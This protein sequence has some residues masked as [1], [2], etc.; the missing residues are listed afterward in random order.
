MTILNDRYKIVAEIAHGGMATIYKAIDL[1]LDRTVA[2]KLLHSHLTKGE[3]GIGFVNRFINEAKAVAK[4]NDPSIVSIYDQCLDGKNVY[5]VMEYVDGKN[6][7]EL[8][9]ES[10]AIPYDKALLVI[11][12]ILNALVVAHNNGIIHRDIKPENIMVDRSG[13]IRLTDFGIAKWDSNTNVSL[14]GNVLGTVTYMSPELVSGKQ[15]MFATDLYSLGIV[16]YELITAE[17]PF[18]GENPA[19]IALQHVKGEFPQIQKVIIPQNVQDFLD[20]LTKLDPNERPKDAVEAKKELNN[21][22]NVISNSTQI[23]TDVIK[24]INHEKTP[25]HDKT[26]KQVQNQSKSEA[27]GVKP[28]MILPRED[29]SLTAKYK[30][31]LYKYT[32]FLDEENSDKTKKKSKVKVVILLF[33]FFIVGAVGAFIFMYFG[34]LSQIQMPQEIQGKTLKQVQAKLS[35]SNIEY[36]VSYEFNDKIKKDLVITT[37]PQPGKY[38]KKRDLIAQIIVSKGIKKIKFPNLINKNW[39]AAEKTLKNLGF[40]NIREKREYL[41]EI[42][43]NIVYKT[44]QKIDSKVEYNKKIDI[45][46]SNGPKPVLMPDITGK[47]IETVKAIL[48]E[49]KLSYEVKYDYS[50]TVKKDSVISQNTKTGTSLL[51]GDNVGFTI[52]LGKPLV[53][54]PNLVGKTTDEAHKQLDALGLKYNDNLILEGLFKTVRSQ[55]VKAG[56]KITKGS[57]ITLTIV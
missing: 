1:N 39:E 54:M 20:H 30:N 8:L 6:L 29:V 46:V 4:L 17:Q 35:S 12:R 7:R 56:E 50:E 41:L 22:L 42:K 51:W 33:V 11:D 28:T 3:G 23:L 14:T 25:L 5:I 45:Y 18:Q 34:P 32:P 57:T 16:L 44:S 37:Y 26:L 10:G 31:T 40:N 52:S 15:A 36:K 2:I 49:L 38:V 9:K 55:S 13:K 19:N 48:L 53:I 43:E 21:L 24:T 47:D 27:H